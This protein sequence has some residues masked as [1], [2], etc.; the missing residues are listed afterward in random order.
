[1]SELPEK[2]RE[3][4]HLRDIEECEMSEIALIVG[5]EEA[6]IRMNLSRARKTIREKLMKIMNHGI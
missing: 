2:Q 3:I 4:M 5:T 1:M 6:S